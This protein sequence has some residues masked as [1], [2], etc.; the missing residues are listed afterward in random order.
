MPIYRYK[1]GSCKHEEELIQSISEGDGYLDSKPRC[2]KCDAP[3]WHRL[4]SLGSFQLQ[5][6]RW[7]RDGY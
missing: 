7:Y 4:I 3:K 6:K 5:G 2:P 1:C